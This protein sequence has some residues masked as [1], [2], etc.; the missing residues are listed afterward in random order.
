MI[1]IKFAWD[2]PFSYFEAVYRTAYYEY[3]SAVL[4][5][6][7]DSVPGHVYIE[8]YQRGLTVE[9]IEDDLA[10]YSHWMTV[11]EAGA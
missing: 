6:N 3:E 1:T 4:R 5:Y 8:I 10:K 11:E 2:T 7:D 9:Q